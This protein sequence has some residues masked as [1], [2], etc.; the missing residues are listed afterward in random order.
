MLHHLLLQLLLSM[1]FYQLYQLL[2]LV[3]RSIV[4]HHF[5]IQV[6]RLVLVVIRIDESSGYCISGHYVV[7]RLM[8][9]VVAGWPGVDGF[10]HS[11]GEVDFIFGH[12]CM[13]R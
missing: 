10:V 7:L 1:R 6:V 12:D 13:R 4:G 3:V 8:T 2:L 5:T 9:A 11:P